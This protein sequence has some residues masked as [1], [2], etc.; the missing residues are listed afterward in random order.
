MNQTTQIH[1][2]ST[3][4]QHYYGVRTLHLRASV[5]PETPSARPQIK[6]RTLESLIIGQKHGT[7]LVRSAH[8][9]LKSWEITLKT[10]HAWISTQRI[11]LQVGLSRF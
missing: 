6:V 11:S 2:T 7:M 3:Y 5:S 8:K 4:A 10:A 1:T 9:S